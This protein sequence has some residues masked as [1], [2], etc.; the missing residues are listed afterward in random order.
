MGNLTCQTPRRARSAAGVRCPPYLRLAAVA[1]FVLPALHAQVV[2]PIPG[3][4]QDY[5]GQLRLPAEFTFEQEI[6]AGTHHYDGIRNVTLTGSLSYIHY[7]YSPETSNYK[8]H[9]WRITAVGTLKQPLSAGS[10]YEQ[11]R[12]EWLDFRA[13]HGAVE[14]LP[15]LRFRLAR[16]STS[17]KAAPN[18]SRRL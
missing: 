9:E 13:S 5:T 8:H 14:H 15:R 12:F 7:F 1:L 4:L 2:D 10:L 3:F 16:I 18:V 11:I 17:E 6:Q